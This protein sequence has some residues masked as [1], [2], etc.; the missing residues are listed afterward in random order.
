MPLWLDILSGILIIGLLACVITLFVIK[1][2]NNAVGKT[3]A[4]GKAGTNGNNGPQGPAGPPGP[5]RNAIFVYQASIGGPNDATSTG[6]QNYS[7]ALYSY[8]SGAVFFGLN[9][10][11]PKIG[12][13]YSIDYEA[14]FFNTS[15]TTPVVC[16]VMFRGSQSPEDTI[17][18]SQ[19]VLAS[20]RLLI[21]G[22]VHVYVTG[23]SPYTTFTIVAQ[24][25]GNFTRTI[26]SFT[27]FIPPFSLDVFLPNTVL[28][29]YL[30]RAFYSI[31]ALK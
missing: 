22:T 19:T 1:A 9:S 25:K 18:S 20:S 4:T 15:N 6:T 14:G 23:I 7:L 31:T 11:T 17:I 16:S 28:N 8:N 29:T 10:I 2:P 27:S 12:D 21:L 5:A 3:G 13:M 26:K 30:E 24:N